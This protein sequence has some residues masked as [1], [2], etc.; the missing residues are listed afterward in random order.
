MAHDGTDITAT[1]LDIQKFSVNDGPGIR[2]TVFLKGCPL[3]CPWCSNPESQ[4]R[5]PQMEWNATACTGCGH[6]LGLLAPHGARASVRDGKR[7]VDVASVDA[8]SALAAQAVREC[9][10]GALSVSGERRSLEDVLA[11]CLQDVPFYAESGGGV[12][13]SG[14]EALLWPGFV[15]ALADRLH[16]RGISTCIETTSYASWDTF[17][18]VTKRMDLLLCDLKHWDDAR[19]QKVVG[20]PL[21]PIV[22]NIARAI[23]RGADVLVRIP[24][25][26]GFNFDPTDPTTS[27]EGFSG[28]LHEVGATRVQLLPYH[29]LGVGKYALL[30]RDYALS[31]APALHPEDLAGLIAAFADH[32]IEAFT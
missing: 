23:G 7:H 29:N 32:G 19:H 15:C 2:T 6:C 18:R 14:G 12:T 11:V 9:P 30:E 1:V 26:P 28:R 21:A 8:T 31:D 4:A 13:F 16:G 25:I 10:A 27:A 17:R 20:A 5:E 24:V 3:L 22:R